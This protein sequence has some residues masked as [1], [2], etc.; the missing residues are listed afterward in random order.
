MS[1][2]RAPFALHV[3]VCTGGGTCPQQG[4]SAVHAYLKGAVAQAGLRDKVRINQSGCLDQCGHGPM[5]VVYPDNVWYS[6]VSLDD[7]KLIFSEHILGGRPVEQLRFH[8]P[9]PGGHK[10][11]RDAAGLPL[12]RCTICRSQMRSAE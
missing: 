12:E 7:A 6:H 9:A 2:V 8:A 11:R 1:E 10:L 5:V 4:S 3:F